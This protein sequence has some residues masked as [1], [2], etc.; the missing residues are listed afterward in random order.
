[1]RNIRVRQWRW[2]NSKSKNLLEVNGRSLKKP[3]AMWEEENIA[4]VFKSKFPVKY[5]TSPKMLFKFPWNLKPILRNESIVSLWR[6][7]HFYLTLTTA[8]AVFHPTGYCHLAFFKTWQTTSYH[9]IRASNSRTEPF[10]IYCCACLLKNNGIVGALCIPSFKNTASTAYLAFRTLKQNDHIS[11]IM[12]QNTVLF[13]PNK[14]H[15]LLAFCMFSNLSSPT[16]R[17]PQE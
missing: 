10:A 3:M 8:G 11:K 13:S 14:H 12:L 17:S 4:R 1:M 6:K 5:R 2:V 7:W 9:R 16:G 15:V